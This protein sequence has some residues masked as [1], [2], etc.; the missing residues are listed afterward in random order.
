MRH[1]HTRHH[2]PPVR[3]SAADAVSQHLDVPSLKLATVAP[4]P[5]SP[6]L[7]PHFR[8]GHSCNHPT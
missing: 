4:Q 3:V 2:P 7:F 6:S 8:A 5:P 1:P